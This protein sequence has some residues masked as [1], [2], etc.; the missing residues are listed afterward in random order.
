M[1]LWVCLECPSHCMKEGEKPE[2]CRYPTL[3][4]RPEVIWH[5]LPFDNVEVKKYCKKMGIVFLSPEEAKE[6]SEHIRYLKKELDAL[7]LKK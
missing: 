6:Y 1:A 3:P 2:G 7:E 5:F 4:E